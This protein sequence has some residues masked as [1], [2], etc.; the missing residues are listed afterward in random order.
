MLYKTRLVLPQIVSNRKTWKLTLVFR[1]G[2]DEAQ[3]ALL[4]LQ[5]VCKC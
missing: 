5:N 1:K 2:K 4:L 3:T